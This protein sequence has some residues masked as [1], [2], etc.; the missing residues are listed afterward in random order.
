[1]RKNVSFAV[2]FL[3]RCCFSSLSALPPSFP[4]SY[5]SKGRLLRGGGRFHSRS[6]TDGSKGRLA[7]EPPREKKKRGEQELETT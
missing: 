3:V 6:D 5:L 1:V 4:P 2:L 7:L